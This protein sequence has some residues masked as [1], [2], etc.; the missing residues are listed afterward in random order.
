MAHIGDIVSKSGIFTDPGVIVEKKPDGNVVVNTDPMEINKFH[1]YAN[2]S[3]LTEG[4]KIRFNSILDEIYQ[5]ENSVERINGIQQ[6]ID[7]LKMDPINKNII[8]Y[9]RNQQAYLVRQSKQLPTSYQTD[10][11]KAMKG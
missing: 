4:E 11:S 7:T 9:L 6:Q 8:R 3:G 10:E 2:T 5:S 1:R